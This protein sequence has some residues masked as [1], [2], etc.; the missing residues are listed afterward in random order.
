MQHA[1]NL[2]RGRIPLALDVRSL[3]LSGMATLRSRGHLLGSRSIETG[4]LGALR[5]DV[6]LEQH[7]GAGPQLNGTAERNNVRTVLRTRADVVREAATIH[8]QAFAQSRR[9][10]ASSLLCADRVVLSDDG[11]VL[12]M[13]RVP[14]RS[15]TVAWG[16]GA[17]VVVLLPAVLHSLLLAGAHSPTLRA[18]VMLVAA[19]GAVAAGVECARKLLLG[20][21][22][23][24]SRLPMIE[25]ANVASWPGG[26][27]AAGR[28]V[29]HAIESDAVRGRAC[30]VRVDPANTIAL[31]LYRSRGFRPI[32]ESDDGSPIPLLRSCGKADKALPRA[33]V[34]VP[35]FVIGAVLAVALSLEAVAGTEA[36]WATVVG[37]GAGL[38]ALAHGAVTDLRSFRIP[39]WSVGAAIIAA[40]V[41]GAARGALPDLLLGAAIGAAPFL[42]IHLLDPRSL[43][44]GDVKFAAAAGALV[45]VLWW[46]GAVLTCLVALA[47]SLI[48]R[49][50]H[51]QPRP[52]GPC[53]FA[54]TVAALIAASQVIEQG[55]VPS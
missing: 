21:R 23:R 34:V 8:S 37:I 46:P 30:V 24:R 7:A 38:A 19:I 41:A 39:N 35:T 14:S 31:A 2:R 54:G 20:F 32:H 50:I 17:V 26:R 10:S 33:S 16:L 13:S 15:G 6:S 29:D 42:L 12:S 53:L 18:V 55:V 36:G 52:F 11:A 28:L 47:V 40:A 51:P 22:W 25:L 3:Y 27:G 45:G 9:R 49:T 48:A 4:G 1:R 5:P 43:G 44:F